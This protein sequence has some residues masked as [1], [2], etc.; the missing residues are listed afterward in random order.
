MAKRNLDISVQFFTNM[1]HIIKN[2][3]EPFIIFQFL[4]GEL[5]NKKGVPFSMLTWGFNSILGYKKRGRLKLSKKIPQSV[6]H[7]STIEMYRLSFSKSDSKPILFSLRKNCTQALVI[8][9]QWCTWEKGLF[10]EAKDDISKER[11]K[12]YKK[13]YHALQRGGYL[14]CT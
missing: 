3:Y 8:Q 2:I 4:F 11:K 5:N 1:L 13:M 7:I 12:S 9:V 10:S 14:L 6:F